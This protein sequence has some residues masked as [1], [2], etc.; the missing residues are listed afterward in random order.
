M[1]VVPV[2]VLSLVY[3]LACF[4]VSAVYASG[5]VVTSLQNQ[6]GFASCP[7]LFKNKSRLALFHSAPFYCCALA[8]RPHAPTP[9]AIRSSLLP[10]PFFQIIS[11][12]L[13]FKTSHV[14]AA[15]MLPRNSRVCC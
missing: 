5:P 11:W 10:R 9:P 3:L 13:G 12:T 8:R 14:C 7:L 2:I 6:Q 1:P 4:H 15:P